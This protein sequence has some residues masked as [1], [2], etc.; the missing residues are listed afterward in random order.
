MLATKS[1]MQ[2]TYIALI[3]YDPQRILG[4]AA[5]ALPNEDLSLSKWLGC[6]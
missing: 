2:L 3:V 5:W 4:P 1:L 6:Q